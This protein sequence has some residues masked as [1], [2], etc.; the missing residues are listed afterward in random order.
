MATT[1]V[2]IGSKYNTQIPTLQSDADIQAAL[3]LYHYGAVLEPDTLISDSIAGHLGALESTKVTKLPVTLPLISTNNDLNTRN[4]T[5]FYIQGTQAGA[6][7]GANYPTYLVSSTPTYG[8][9]MLE[10]V[11]DGTTIY[12]VYHMTNGASSGSIVNYKFWR[13]KYSGTWNNW[14]RSSEVGHTHNDLYPLIGDVQPLI[15]GAASTIT[16]NQ[17]TASRI[18][19]SDASGKIGTSDIPSSYISNITSNVQTQIDAKPN[20]PANTMF[21]QSATP[22][23]GVQDG[24]LWFW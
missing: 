9:G 4:V 20:S 1:S 10:V 2:N 14:T 3:H 8:A 24:D 12:Q 21:V 11:S 22:T 13:A 7:A 18:V 15:L 19:T 17:L 16:I 23:I 5:G 6:A